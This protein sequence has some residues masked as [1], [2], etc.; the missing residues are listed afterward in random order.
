MINDPYDA[1]GDKE[2]IIVS[3]CECDH[4]GALSMQIFKILSGGKPKLFFDIWHISNSKIIGANY[5]SL[6]SWFTNYFF[7]ASQNLTDVYLIPHA[8]G[9]VS[10]GAVQLVT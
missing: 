3:S 8:F 7:T 9:K 4:D 6:P 5:G 2:S 1:E 10:E